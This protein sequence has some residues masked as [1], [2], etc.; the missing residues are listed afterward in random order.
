MV[1]HA[2]RRPC[3]LVAR[4]EHFETSFGGWP[5]TAASAHAQAANAPCRGGSSGQVVSRDRLAF[6]RAH[7]QRR[8]PT[9]GCHEPAPFCGERRSTGRTAMP[10]Q[11][12]L[13]NDK[14]APPASVLVASIL[15]PFGLCA[16][17]LTHVLSS[18][19]AGCV[20]YFWASSVP[21]IA[22]STASNGRGMRYPSGCA[23]ACAQPGSPRRKP[24]RASSM[25]C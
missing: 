21:L 3:D 14:L 23:A 24:G 8:R 9:S 7:A 2:A 5:Q 17:D 22:A 4:R 16:A 25:R 15:K 12:V 18:L 20:R 19:R 1:I 10:S 11:R 6:W 13:R